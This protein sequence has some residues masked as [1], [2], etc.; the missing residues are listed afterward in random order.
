MSDIRSDHIRT[1]GPDYE[2]VVAIYTHP[3]GKITTRVTY[4][5]DTIDAFERV[6]NAAGIEP[7]DLRQEHVAGTGS[8]PAHFYVFVERGR[9]TLIYSPDYVTLKDVNLKRSEPAAVEL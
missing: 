6:C 5:T 1:N 2:I 8:A 4:H 9:S 7:S 3:R